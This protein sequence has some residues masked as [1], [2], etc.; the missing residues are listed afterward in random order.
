MHGKLEAPTAE[1]RVASTSIGCLGA[2]LVLAAG[3][4]AECTDLNYNGGRKR[5]LL[6]EKVWLGSADTGSSLGHVMSLNRAR[7]VRLSTLECA[8]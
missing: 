5:F 4:S 6:D 1:T 7:P 3:E 2:S 8:R